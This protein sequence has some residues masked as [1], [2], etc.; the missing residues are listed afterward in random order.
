MKRILLFSSPTENNIDTLL[1][2]I[3]PDWIKNKVFAYM[4]S[5][6]AS[7]PQ[8][9]I[10][11]W[12]RYAQDHNAEFRYIDNS[13]EEAT[14]EIRK[15]QGSNILVITGGNTFKL[16]DNLRKSGLD[17]A[18]KELAN[19]DDFVLAG[20]SAGALV[21]TPTIQICNLPNYDDNLV[22]IKDLTGLN[23]VDFEVFPHYEEAKQ[24]DALNEY[25]VTTKNVVKE[26]TNDNYLVIEH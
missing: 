4:P 7:C 9:Y 20:F 2:L 16:L 13:K 15:L 26:I 23:I 14:E 8:K 19:K 24:K 1:T 11:E 25:R 12:K 21:L 10:D 22:G 3:F 5:D 17:N 6:G 18:V